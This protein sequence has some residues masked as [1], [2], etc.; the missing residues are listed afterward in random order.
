M[1]TAIYAQRVLRVAKELATLA[2]QDDDPDIRR[3]ARRDAR[4]LLDI[5][6]L[7][8]WRRWKS[9]KTKVAQCRSA[10]FVPKSVKQF[11]GRT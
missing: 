1:K 5:A 7:L 4:S 10:I 11:L 3:L 6:R 2:V 9:A 8:Q